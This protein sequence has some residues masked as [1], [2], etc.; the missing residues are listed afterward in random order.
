MESTGFIAIVCVCGLYGPLRLVVMFHLES[1]TVFIYCYF[2]YFCH[3][4]ICRT[5]LMIDSEGLGHRA[6]SSMAICAI[7]VIFPYSPLLHCKDRDDYDCY[8][9]IHGSSVEL[10]RYYMLIVRV[11]RLYSHQRDCHH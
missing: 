4:S 7:V 3:S 9:Y 10:D 11:L 6:W 1:I 8:G 5:F 2:S